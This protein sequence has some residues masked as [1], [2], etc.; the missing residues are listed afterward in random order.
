MSVHP[1]LAEWAYVSPPVDAVVTY[2]DGH[3][4][5][6]DAVSA[7]RFTVINKTKGKSERVVYRTWLL[8]ER[9]MQGKRSDELFLDSASAKRI[10]ALWPLE[11]GETLTHSFRTESRGKL[12]S[13]GTQ[14]LT[15]VGVEQVDVPAGSFQA[16]RLERKYMLTKVSDGLQ[17]HGG[18]ISWHDMATGLV[19][20]VDWWSDDPETGGQGMYLATEMDLP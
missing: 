7:D 8:R 10:V 11:P 20:R 14:V 9:L 2:D 4:S 3:S 16:H 17:Y 12:L 5:R 6:I 15:Y 19:L 1:A 18:E 13:T